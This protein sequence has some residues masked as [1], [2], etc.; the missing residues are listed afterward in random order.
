MKLV[1]C[2][3]TSFWALL[4]AVVMLLS[5]C[6]NDDSN[7]APNPSDDSSEIRM[8]AS[9][10][11]VMPGTRATTFSSAADLQTQGSFMCTAY[12]E[13]TTTANT[14]VDIDGNTV[15]WI[16]AS[17]VF[18]GSR[19]FWPADPL[20]LD[21]FAYMPATIPTYIADM[22]DV[23]QQVTYAARNPQFKCVNLPMSVSGQS[24]ISEFIYGLVEG[25]TKEN[26]PYGITLTFQHP[27]TRIYL[28][29]ANYDHSAITNLSIKLKN[30]KNNGSY[31]HSG[32]WSLTG[33]ATDFTTTTLN[34]YGAA[35]PVA[36][37]MVPQN[38]AGKIEIEADWIDWGENFTHTL[39]TTV[40]TNWEAGHSY[41][42]TFT[43][44][45]REVLVNT[46]KFTE[47]W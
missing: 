6:S 29:W 18:T 40:A 23:G 42:Y 35:N 4:L 45:P 14:E 36:C 20:T 32:G 27:F 10:W 25:R 8:N 12:D 31:S 30:I 34:E 1:M 21:F 3:H 5:A 41:T 16:G 24:S 15:T 11:Q 26:S 9:V 44:T 13:N 43:I 2:Q 38:W 17:W 7:E 39:S 46:E 37:L 19:R 47:Q 22:S 28:N 33:D